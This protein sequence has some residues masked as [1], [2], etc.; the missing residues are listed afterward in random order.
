LNNTCQE[1]QELTTQHASTDS[2]QHT[3]F[4]CLNWSNLRNELGAL[5][6]QPTADDLPYFLCG[7]DFNLLPEDPEKKTTML[8]NVAKSFGLLY[9]M[10][11]NILSFKE[12]E[13]RA[14]QAAGRRELTP[15][16]GVQYAVKGFPNESPT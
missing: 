16:P 13:E 11:E 9:K 6:H 8:A 15:D 5:R 1:W 3:I 7:P 2:T 10:V 4:A 14:R 12:T